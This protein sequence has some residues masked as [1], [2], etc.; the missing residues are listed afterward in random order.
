[1]SD[2]TVSALLK[3]LERFGARSDA[4]TRDGSRKMLNITPETG[5]F[6]AIMIR[7]MKARR[8]LEIGTSNGYS[9]LWLARAARP[10]RGTVTTVDHSAYKA[11]LA[12][13]NFK[14]A[15]LARWIRMREA[16]AAEFLARDPGPYDFV[17]LDSA[18]EQYVS[19]WPRVR[20][21]VAPGGLLA[22]DNALTHPRELAAFIRAVGRTPGWRSVTV[23]IG[24]GEFL[25]L[26]GR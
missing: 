7:A 4:R 1:M 12:R 8:I 16:D 18:R 14:R 9:T 19:W 26:R 22:A 17:F 21:L 24:N 3:E 15:G 13:A 23:P 5:A 2:E 6:F 25:A 10:L 11:E 20:R